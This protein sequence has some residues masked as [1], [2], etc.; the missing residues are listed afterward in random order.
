MPHLS[1]PELT[2][3]SGPVVEPDGRE[4]LY[5]GAYV[6]ENAPSEKKMKVHQC[7]GFLAVP[8]R[9]PTMYPQSYNGWVARPARVDESTIEAVTTSVI[10]DA[11]YEQQSE[12]VDLQGLKALIG[13]HAIIPPSR[14]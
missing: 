6:P 1:R 11:T 14:G 5:V 3:I 2:I 12:P 8:D 7:I 10:T 4:R 13:K 9:D